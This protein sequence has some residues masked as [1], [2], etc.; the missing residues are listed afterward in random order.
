MKPAPPFRE[1]LGWQRVSY[2]SQNH[3]LNFFFWGKMN[4]A[5]QRYF[6]NKRI[7][8]TGAGG[9]IGSH[10]TEALLEISAGVRAFAHYNSRNDW[11]FL[12]ELPGVAKSSLH[13]FPADLRDFHAVKQ[14]TK[15]MDIVFHLGAS[16]GIPYSLAYPNDVVETNVLGTLNVLKASLE[17]EVPRV[18]HTSTSEVYGTARY[19]P[20]DEEHPLTPQSPYAASK[21]AAD[22]L[23]ESFFH[24]YGLPVS[25]IRPFNTFGPR[26]SLRAI[27]P[28]II[29]QLLRGKK[30]SV[31]NLKPRRDFTFVS[32][33]VN[34]FILLASKKGVAGES[35][36]LGTG[37]EITIQ[38]LVGRISG[39][40]G[41]TP[42]IGVDRRRVRG[43]QSEVMRLL[44]DNSKAVKSLGWKPKS[45]LE[46]GLRRTIDWLS[47]KEHF[48]KSHIYN[49]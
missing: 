9:F 42:E 28:T 13:V 1:R 11:G 19:V 34:G 8:I 43:N 2:P 14:A 41:V 15:G 12:E 23:A 32:D 29:T 48:G 35:F 38:E 40:M 7:L 10:L 5:V 31:G 46:E 25:I 26:Q 37:K 33:T 45:T 36:N 16:I 49:I 47:D 18:I 21:I 24:S 22:K 4:S 30:A 20:M 6:K 27:I 39:M 44:S 3:I 17:N